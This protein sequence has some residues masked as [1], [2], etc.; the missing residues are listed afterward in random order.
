ML[1][2]QR[3]KEKVIATVSMR[4]STNG[5]QPGPDSENMLNCTRC[6]AEK[7]P[8]GITFGMAGGD[9]WRREG[10][11]TKNKIKKSDKKPHEIASIRWAKSA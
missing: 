8:R 10:C 7:R 3:V 2:P 11:P 5:A 6:C 4:Q 1:A 9:R